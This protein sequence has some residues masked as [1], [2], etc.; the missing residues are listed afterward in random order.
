MGLD[1]KT[2]LD[3][4]GFALD[5]GICDAPDPEI[6]DASGRLK[7]ALPRGWKKEGH[8][9]V[10][11]PDNIRLVNAIEERLERARELMGAEIPS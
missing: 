5:H 11:P 9:W 4:V 2:K 6:C 10:S 1:W 8:N 7:I 3:D